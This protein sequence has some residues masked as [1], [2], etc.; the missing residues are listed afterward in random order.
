MKEIIGRI[1]RGFGYWTRLFLAILVIVLF[2][3]TDIAEAVKI[4]FP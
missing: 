3:V 1:F 2:Y 4:I